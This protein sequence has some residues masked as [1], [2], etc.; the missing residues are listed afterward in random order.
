MKYAASFVVFLL[1]VVS[2]FNL[3][4]HSPKPKVS[5]L[6]MANKVGVFFGTSTGNTE[7]VAE[8]IADKLGAEGPFDVDGDGVVQSF[9]KFDSLIVGTPT[10]NTGR[11]QGR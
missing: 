4:L 1:G 2:S 7:T 5:A 9:L 6:F 11:F 10:W 8:M 3:H